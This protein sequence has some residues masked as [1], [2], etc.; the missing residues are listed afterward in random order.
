[1]PTLPAG[2]FAKGCYEFD[3]NVPMA[4]SI[5]LTPTEVHAARAGKIGSDSP[6]GWIASDLGT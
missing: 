3:V 1:M 2:K 4:D 6:K 5:E